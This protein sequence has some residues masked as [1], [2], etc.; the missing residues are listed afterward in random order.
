MTGVSDITYQGERDYSIRAWLDPQKL[1]ACNMTAMDVANAIQSAEHRRAG[2]PS[3]P[4]ARPSRDRRYQLPIDTLGRLTEPEQFGDI[5]VKVGPSG[6]GLRSVY[7]TVGNG[8]SAG[9]CHDERQSHRPAPLRIEQ[10][11]HEQHDYRAVRTTSGTT[12]S[13]STSTTG[14]H[15]RARAA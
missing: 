12:S 13:S 14:Q 1:A 8:M 15:D 2:R 5:I 7:A 10:P 11:D 6:G 9:G 4:A 3:R